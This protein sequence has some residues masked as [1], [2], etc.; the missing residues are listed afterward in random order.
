MSAPQSSSAKRGIYSPPVSQLW[1][2]IYWTLP[3]SIFIYTLPIDEIY[4]RYF[5]L[6]PFVCEYNIKIAP[7]MILSKGWIHLI[8]QFVLVRNSWRGKECNKFCT[9]TATTTFAFSSVYIILLQYVHPPLAVKVG[10][11]SKHFCCYLCLVL[12]KILLS[13]RH[14]LSNTSQSGSE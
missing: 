10:T 9:Q 11:N 1:D 3:L 5:C 6:T 7:R 13:W 12:I 2:C 8:L 14:E 4:S